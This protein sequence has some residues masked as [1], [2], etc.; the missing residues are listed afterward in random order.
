MLGEK[1]AGERCKMPVPSVD[2][3]QSRVVYV[4]K[5]PEQPRP[6]HGLEVDLWN[7]IHGYVLTLPCK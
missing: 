6:D 4:I 1:I 7:G 5:S 3:M 2:S